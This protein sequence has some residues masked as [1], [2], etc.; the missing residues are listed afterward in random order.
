MSEDEPLGTRFESPVAAAAL[1]REMAKL[2]SMVVVK[3]LKSSNRMM[4][5]LYMSLLKS[6]C[7]IILKLKIIWEDFE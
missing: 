7:Q 2:R 5:R 1:R 3:Q 6:I 4:P